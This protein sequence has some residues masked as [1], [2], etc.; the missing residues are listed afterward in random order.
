[1]SKGLCL[2]AGLDL[3]GN[4]PNILIKSTTF[5]LILKKY[6]KLIH[7]FL[8]KLKLL[9]D[10]D[11]ERADFSNDTELCLFCASALFNT[12]TNPQD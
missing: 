4:I 9:E 3:I 11:T 8:T 5:I 6:I 2:A 1:M 7:N 10:L 12:N